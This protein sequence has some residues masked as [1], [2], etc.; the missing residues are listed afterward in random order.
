MLWQMMVETFGAHPSAQMPST[1][2]CAMALHAP[3]MAHPD[4]L[5]WLSDLERCIAWAW[6]TR[7]PVLAS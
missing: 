7:N 5:E 2:W 4:V 6:M 1:P 3:L